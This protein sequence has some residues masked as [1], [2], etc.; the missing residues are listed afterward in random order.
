MSVSFGEANSMG[1]ETQPRTEAPRPIDRAYMDTSVRPGDDFFQY[2]NGTWLKNTTIPDDET[3]WGGFA[4][5][6]DRNL[7]VLH[8]ILEEAATRPGDL[9]GDL[10]ASGMDEAGIERA[11]LAS[12]ADI[13]RRADGLT[14]RSELPRLLGW[15]RRRGVNAALA[16]RVMPD[17]FNSPRDLLHLTQSG[18]RLADRDY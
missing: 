16:V 3:G 11:G 7:T 18:L 14:D 2:A 13:L 1:V 15:L 8:E 6:R 17:A 12:V 4:E 5:V 10:Y 9:V